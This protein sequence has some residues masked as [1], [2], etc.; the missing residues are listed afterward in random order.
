MRWVCGC[1]VLWCGEARQGMARRQRWTRVA[2]TFAL[3]CFA[4]LLIDEMGSG[5]GAVKSVSN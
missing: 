3:L 4:L 2:A 1:V 5:D